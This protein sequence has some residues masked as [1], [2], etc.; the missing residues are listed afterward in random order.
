MKIDDDH[1]YHGAV[2][3]QI[4]EHPRF[5]AINTI[6]LSGQKSRSAYRINDRIGIFLKYASKP[7]KTSAN[8][9]SHSLTTT[10]EN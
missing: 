5:T 1:M 6:E 10:C 9:P 8:T 3:L 7:S 4:A 2:L